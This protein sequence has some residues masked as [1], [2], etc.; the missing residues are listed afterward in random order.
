MPAGFYVTVAGLPIGFY[1]DQW[2][3]DPAENWTVAQLAADIC[4]TVGCGG[5]HAITK[6][7]TPLANSRLVA[8]EVA[9]GDIIA[10]TEV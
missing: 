4:D 3:I 9:A 5:S 1:T 7:D 10:L 2:F 6:D 8:D